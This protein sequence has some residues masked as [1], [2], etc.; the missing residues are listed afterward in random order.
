MTPAARSAE[1]QAADA[2][3]LESKTLDGSP[4]T[5]GNSVWGGEYSALW[6]VLDSLNAP[7][8]TLKFTARKVDTSITSV[9]LVWRSHP[10]WRIDMDH[11][12]HTNPPDAWTM[13]LPSVVSAPHEH[14]WSINRGYVLTSDQWHLPYRRPLPSNIRRLGQALLWLAD[15]INLRIEP[16]QRGFEAPTRTGL[17]DR[18]PG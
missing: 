12:S 3:I 5:W 6:I 7:A 9:S 13:D 10:L 1:I 14:A 17:F 16:E 4:P 11:S 8:A 2:F 15:Q 18:N